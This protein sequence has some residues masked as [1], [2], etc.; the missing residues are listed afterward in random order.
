MALGLPSDGTRAVAE[1]K[2]KPP[3]RRREA[4]RPLFPGE[5]AAWA[6]PYR[7]TARPASR[8]RGTSRGEAVVRAPAP[9]YEQPSWWWVTR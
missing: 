1:A 6:E 4:A 8:R 3:A 5:E 2:P 7:E 9:M